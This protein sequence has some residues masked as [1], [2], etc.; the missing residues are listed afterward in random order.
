[1]I[2]IENIFLC[3]A[4]PLLM[5]LFFVKGPTRRFTLFLVMGMGMSLLS[6]YVSSFFMSY[7]GVDTM[8]TAVEITPV[9]EEIMKLLPLLFYILIF[10]PEER[11]I[12]ASAIAIAAG[13]ATFENACYLVQ[14][15]AA[16]F[17]YM[18]VRGFSAGALHILCGIICGYGLAFA[19]RY[20]WLCVTGTFGILGFC[21]SFHAIY[22]LLITGKGC[23]ATAGY[24]FPSL[25][26]VCLFAARLAAPKMEAR[27]RESD[28]ESVPDRN[29][30]S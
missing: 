21:V 26:I 3:L 27:L 29:L 17:Q 19:F 24:L 2:Y 22:N 15:G 25:L 30:S 10:E 7:Y 18:M 8:A 5:A 9:C 6:A 12:Q 20:R 1:M 14:N 13:F 28:S 4:I 23:F 16:S 11:R